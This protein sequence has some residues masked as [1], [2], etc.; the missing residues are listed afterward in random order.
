MTKTISA[1][2]ARKNLGEILNEVYYSG[3]DYIIERAGKP[4]VRLIKISF[5]EKGALQES[6]ND[7]V[8]HAKKT[9]K[10]NKTN[11][12]SVLDNLE[13]NRV[14]FYQNYLKDYSVQS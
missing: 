7:V 3:N 6:L 12:S 11:L 1:I 13:K 2:K 14:E 5:E 8:T 9:L 10:R 4:M